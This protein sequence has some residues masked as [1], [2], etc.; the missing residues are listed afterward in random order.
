VISV[1]LIDAVVFFIVRPRNRIICKHA[2]EVAIRAC[3]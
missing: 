3:P 1:I 2:A